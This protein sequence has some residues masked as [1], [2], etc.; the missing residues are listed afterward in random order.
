MREVKIFHAVE[1][2]RAFGYSV[3]EA[4][5]AFGEDKYLHVRSFC[6][7]AEDSHDA[8]MRAVFIIGFS[9]RYI[10]QRMITSPVPRHTTFGDIIEIS[11]DLMLITPEG[12]L[13][14]LPVVKAR[15]A[16]KERRGSC[17]SP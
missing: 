4:A 9:A 14:V 2:D 11:N 13:R 17:I 3:S 10:Q 12:L 1:V 16:S 7:A 5:V 8:F 6:I 15:P